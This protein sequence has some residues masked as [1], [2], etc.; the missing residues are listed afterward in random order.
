M[1]VDGGD[2]VTASKKLLY[3][4]LHELPKTSDANGYNDTFFQALQLRLGYYLARRRRLPT[5]R[6]SG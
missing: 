6:P 4:L 5:C 3:G 1:A 2:V